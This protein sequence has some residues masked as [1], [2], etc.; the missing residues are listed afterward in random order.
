[1]KNTQ[2]SIKNVKKSH[3]FAKNKVFLAIFSILLF[4]CAGKTPTETIID[5]HIEH[6]QDVLDFA[7]NNFEQTKDV[8]YLENELDSC[9]IALVDAKA[10]YQSEIATCKAKTDYWRLATGGLL[11][12]VVALIIAIIKRW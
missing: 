4:G 2:N 3:L 11:I 5:G 9:R 10:S 8:I 1:M 7:K 12:A 6:V